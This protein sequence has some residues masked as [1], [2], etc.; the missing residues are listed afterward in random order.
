MADDF[1]QLGIWLNRL[2]KRTARFAFASGFGISWHN[3]INVP[4]SLSETIG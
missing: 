3:A 1:T 4:S 2:H